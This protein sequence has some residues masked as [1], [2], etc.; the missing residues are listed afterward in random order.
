MQNKRLTFIYKL[1]H[2]YFDGGGYFRYAPTVNSSGWGDN[3][4]LAWVEP[5]R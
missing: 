4:F 1:P 3:N 2:G 5:L